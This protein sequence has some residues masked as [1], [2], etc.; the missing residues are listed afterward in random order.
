[1]S[2]TFVVLSNSESFSVGNAKFS[3]KVRS[4]AI[5]AENDILSSISQ[6]VI[7]TPEEL[8]TYSIMSAIE[9]LESSD[10]QISFSMLSSVVESINFGMLE[11]KYGSCVC[12]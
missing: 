1:M 5:S 7:H 10:Q 3:D 12:N 2:E 6:G 4:A 8:E 9:A 11:K